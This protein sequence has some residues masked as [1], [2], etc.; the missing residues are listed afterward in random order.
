MSQLSR[1]RARLAQRALPDDGE[2]KYMLVPLRE[3]TPEELWTI[4]RLQ[5]E[6]FARERREHRATLDTILG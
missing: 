3:F 6:G 1:V 2:A 4:I 5:N